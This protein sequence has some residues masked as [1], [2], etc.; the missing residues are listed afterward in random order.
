MKSFGHIDMN[1]NELQNAI[2]VFADDTSFPDTTKIGQMCF[3]NRILYV[4]IDLGGGIP[5]WVPLTNEI[6][7][8]NHVQSAPASTWTI[9][10]NL[11]TAFPQISV[12][13]NT[14]KKI[15]PNDI[16]IVNENSI[17]VD[18]SIAQAG[19]AVIIVGSV[20]GSPR[21]YIAYTH[22]Q[23]EAST[24]W[25]VSHGLGYNPIIRV[26]IGNAEVQPASI[27]HNDMNTTTITFSTPQTGF[28][29]CI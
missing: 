19:K 20:E 17:S 2:I 15:M 6:N 5:V 24:T 29:R 18:F 7:S 27:I 13:D 4:C 8:Y 3:K 9:T 22:T 14:N 26:F 12:Y 11:K 23:T 1:R 10:H 28:V 21:Q 25:V 16:T